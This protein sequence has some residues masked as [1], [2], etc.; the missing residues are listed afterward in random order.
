M[1]IFMPHEVANDQNQLLA[2]ASRLEYTCIDDVAV[3]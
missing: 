1:D 2:M 3:G